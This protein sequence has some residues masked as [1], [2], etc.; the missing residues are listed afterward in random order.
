[1]APVQQMMEEALSVTASKDSLDQ[2]VKIGEWFMIEIFKCFR[3]VPRY[4]YNLHITM[5]IAL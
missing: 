1:M 4:P 2:D 5:S 3:G